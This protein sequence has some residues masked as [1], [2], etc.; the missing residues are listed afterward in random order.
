MSM[1]EL[2]HMGIEGCSLRM[3]RLIQYRSYC[4]LSALLTVMYTL[5]VMAYLIVDHAPSFSYLINDTDLSKEYYL[6][7]IPKYLVL[8]YI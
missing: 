1:N 2:T 7:I 3:A 6:D 5:F 4:I 8:I